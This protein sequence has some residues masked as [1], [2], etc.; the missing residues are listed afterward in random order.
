MLPWLGP[1][2]LRSALTASDIALAMDQSLAQTPGPSGRHQRGCDRSC[3]WHRETVT[4]TRG[5]RLLTVLPGLRQY[6]NYQRRW[7][8]GDVLAGHRFFNERIEFFDLRQ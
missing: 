1:N 3:E 5:S 4:P 6:K 8:R 7:L 2:R